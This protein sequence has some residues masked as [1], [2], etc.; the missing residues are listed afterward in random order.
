M[1]LTHDKKSLSI[2]HKLGCT[3]A[4]TT[5]EAGKL[6]F[7]SA[8]TDKEIIQFARELDRP[9]GIS[10]KGNQLAV[11]TRDQVIL[12]SDNNISNQNY[13]HYYSP[14]VFYNTGN[15]DIHDLVF[16]KSSLL[17]VNTSMS[18]ISKISAEYSFK[19]IW[20]PDFITQLDLSDKCHLNSVAVCEKYGLLYAS[21]F[22]D[23]NT[24]KEWRTKGGKGGII[25][26]IEN[27]EIICKGLCVPHSV[28]VYNDSVYA[29]LSGTGHLI[30][31]NPETKSYKT[32]CELKGF[33]RGLARCGDYL[34]VGISQRRETS[35]SAISNEFSKHAAVVILDINTHKICG[36]MQY[37]SGVGEIYDIQVI[38]NKV[39]IG[40]SLLNDKTILIP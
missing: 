20:K 35:S 18:C 17:A 23:T 15:S 12:F 26:D 11:S 1:E 27:N 22:A 25:I 29:L 3:L 13:N 30:I 33:V 19:P 14:R 21:A 36:Y 5:Y 7:I 39:N 16:C 32:V 24:E 8:P 6:V 2:L 40:M 31:I 38:E 9:M 4:I 37:E 10:I 28:R 34:F